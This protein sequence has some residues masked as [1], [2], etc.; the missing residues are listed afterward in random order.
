MERVLRWTVL[1]CLLYFFLCVCV[2]VQ[3]LT[4]QLG[5]NITLPCQVPNHAAIV[6]VNWTRPDLGSKYVLFFR[7]GQPDPDNQHPSFENRVELQDPKLKDRNLSLNLKNV[8]SSDYGTYECHVK[9]RKEGG[10]IT[11][12]LISTVKLTEPV[13]GTFDQFRMQP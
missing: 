4:P 10:T 1:T 9:E 12:E 8:G 6:A 11:S 2:S 7:D 3:T 13:S 5:Q